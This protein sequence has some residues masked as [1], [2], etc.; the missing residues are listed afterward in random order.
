MAAFNIPIKID[1]DEE[2]LT[3]EFIKK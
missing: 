1:D 3:T 2:E